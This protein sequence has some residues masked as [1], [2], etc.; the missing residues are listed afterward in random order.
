[1]EI[2]VLPDLNASVTFRFVMSDGTFTEVDGDVI[3]LVLIVT[4][5]EVLEPLDTYLMATYGLTHVVVTVEDELTSLPNDP[6]NDTFRLRMTATVADGTVVARAYVDD[7]RLEVEVLPGTDAT[8]TLTFVSPDGSVVTVPGVVSGTNVDVLGADGGSLASFVQS[9]FGIGSVV[10]EVDDSP[11]GG[12]DDDAD[13]DDGRDDDMDDDRDGDDRDDDRDEDGRD[14]DMDDDR[15]GDDRDGSSDD[16]DDEDD[17]TDED[18]EA[19]NDDDDESDGADE[20]D[21]DEDND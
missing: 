10:V 19:E 21:D 4:G 20:D 3:G 14:D 9:T 6:M 5:G 16:D 1:M 17:D 11:S 13:D 8:V 2:D 18:D 7:G 15:D 12:I